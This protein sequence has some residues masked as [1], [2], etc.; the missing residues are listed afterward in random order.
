MVSCDIAFEA[1]RERNRDCGARF[2]WQEQ[3]NY[4]ESLLSASKA[5]GSSDPSKDEQ[6]RKQQ[7]E[8][9]R[10]ENVLVMKLTTKEQETQDCLV[11][12]HCPI[13]LFSVKLFSPAPDWHDIYVAHWQSI[14]IFLL[15][16]RHE[17]FANCYVIPF[18]CFWFISS[19]YCTI[20]VCGVQVWHCVAAS[21][22]LTVAAVLQTR[23]LGENIISIFNFHQTL[24]W[25]KWQ[26]FFVGIDFCFNRLAL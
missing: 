5:N 9:A 22:N 24:Y 4:I 20:M 14:D 11:L 17:N 6:L 13:L 16:R 2:R 21:D 10:R 23:L 3:E 26:S 8:A 18:G 19:S 25:K 12:L 15:C 7:L 1:V